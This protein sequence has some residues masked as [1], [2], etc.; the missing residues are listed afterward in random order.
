[1]SITVFGLFT[2]V[3]EMAAIFEPLEELS[4]NHDDITVMS[5]A[6]YPEGTFFHDSYESPLWIICLVCGFLGFLG[7]IGLAG[8]TQW[9]IN[10]VVS[11]KPTFSIPPVA[12]IAYEFTLAG[13]VLAT[14]FGMLWYARLPD[15]NKLA[16]SDEISRSKIGLLVRCK[17]EEM[18]A[19]VEELMKKHNVVGAI[20]RGR[21]DY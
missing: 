10:L 14:F 15:W 1:M 18:A 2:K 5:V 3:D 12:I 16:Y 4:V 17:S 19:K 11:G 9:H 13:A 8:L 7:A 21:D 6:P 20:K